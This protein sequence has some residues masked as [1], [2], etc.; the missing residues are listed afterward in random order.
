MSVHPFSSW[1]CGALFAL[2]AVVQPALAGTFQ[3][4]PVLIE[5]NAARR[6][7]NVT[8]RNEDPRPVTIRAYALAWRQEAGEDIYEET[9]AIIVSPPVA[10]VGPGAAQLI[11]VGLRRPSADP[12]AYRLVIEEVPEASPGQGIKVA[13]RLNLPLYVSMKAGLPSELR[14]S[15]TP[16]P[17][18]GWT[19]EAHNPTADYVRLISADVRAATGIGFE[20]SHSFGTLLPGTRRSWVVEASAPIED[21]ARLRRLQ[22]S[23]AHDVAPQ[24]RE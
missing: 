12:K 1:A 4:N 24:G 6:T 16:R 11:R 10:T 2:A 8:I 18:G 14:W 15:A 21:L 19:V 20:D 9:D 22:G 17:G 5:I 13:L 3:V 23:A 7:A